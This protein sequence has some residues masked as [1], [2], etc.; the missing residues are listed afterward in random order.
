MP[1]IVSRDGD[2]EHFDGSQR[3]EDVHPMSRDEFKER[4][5]EGIIRRHRELT[6]RLARESSGLPLKNPIK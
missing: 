4:A 2:D 3:G 6:E 5:L 1:V